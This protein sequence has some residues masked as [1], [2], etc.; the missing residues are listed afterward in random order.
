MFVFCILR[1]GYHLLFSGF[2][3]AHVSPEGIQS[4]YGWSVCN[5]WSLLLAIP[6]CTLVHHA[7]AHVLLD[8]QALQRLTFQ[9]LTVRS[10]LAAQA[11][12]LALNYWFTFCV[13]KAARPK[14]Q[15]LEAP[16]GS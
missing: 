7:T 15:P 2:S 13:L 5:C 14:F 6:K 10:T 9:D 12:V 16:H 3:V 11:R 8:V 4:S 1:H